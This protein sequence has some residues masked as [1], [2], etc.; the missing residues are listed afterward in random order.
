MAIAATKG[1]G[2]DE[3]C[4]TSALVD[5]EDVCG[6]CSDWSMQPFEDVGVTSVADGSE[7]AK[8]P[9]G[10]TRRQAKG[11]E[12]DSNPTSPPQDGQDKH[13]YALSPEAT[14]VAISHAR[15]FPVKILKK[16]VREEET[17][18]CAVRRASDGCYLIQKR[19]DKGKP[20]AP[21]RKI[22]S[23]GY[24]ANLNPPQGSLLGYGNSQASC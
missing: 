20:P 4:D 17:I 5:M 15:K 12:Q 2:Q 11:S 24:E 19:P 1:L 18:V 6:V 8:L 23:R 21:E 22:Q 3:P 10:R 16:T 13:G 14:E 9:S 7:S